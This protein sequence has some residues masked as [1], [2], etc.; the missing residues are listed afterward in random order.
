MRVMSFRAPINVSSARVGTT[1][2]EPG[3]DVANA[4]PP[5]STPPDESSLMQAAHAVGG[6]SFPVEVSVAT[7]AGGAVGL[8]F[9]GWLWGALGAIGSNLAG[10]FGATTYCKNTPSLTGYAVGKCGSGKPPPKKIVCPVPREEAQAAGAPLVLA[11]M[12]DDK[13]VVSVQQIADARAIVMRLDA[14][15]QSADAD[16]VRSAIFAVTKDAKDKPKGPVPDPGG[17]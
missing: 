1:A 7:V 3:G 10:R 13:P 5:K 16:V 9:G 14:C 2:G 6:Y 17:S 4:P 8:F 11:L 15:G 12:S